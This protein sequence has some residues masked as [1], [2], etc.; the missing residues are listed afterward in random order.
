MRVVLILVLLTGCAASLRDVLPSDGESLAD[1]AKHLNVTKTTDRFT[2]TTTATTTVVS[3]ARGKEV[4][5]QYAGIACGAEACLLSFDYQIPMEMSWRYTAV[6]SS[7]FLLD[8]G[9]PFSLPVERHV[10][11]ANNMH[12]ET[13]RMALS[14]DNLKAVLAAKKV[15]F[16]LG[17]DEFEL[18]D[19]ELHALRVAQALVHTEHPETTPTIAKPAPPE[20]AETQQ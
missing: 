20:Q 3:G 17:G 18:S 7:D 10:D 14:G 1:E 16:R 2:N 5:A 4:W 12:V 13:E 8:G 11:I 9:H 19:R 6:T 15:E